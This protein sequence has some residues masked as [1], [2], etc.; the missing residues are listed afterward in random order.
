MPLSFGLVGS[1]GTLNA[2]PRTGCLAFSFRFEIRVLLEPTEMA[3]E[4]PVAMRSSALWRHAVA[5]Q[6]HRLWLDVLLVLSA[7][8]C[9]RA[10]PAVDVDD[11][12]VLVV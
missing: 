3:M 12:L 2:Q 10:V 4:H 11:G 7:Q 5:Q 1:R 8:L 9:R 6:P